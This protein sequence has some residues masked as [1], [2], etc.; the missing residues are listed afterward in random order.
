MEEEVEGGLGRGPGQLGDTGQDAPVQVAHPVVEQ[1]PLAPVQRAQHLRLA[2][3][4]RLLGSV[5]IRFVWL[6]C[7][8]KAHT[9]VCVQMPPMTY[10]SHNHFS[11]LHAVPLSTLIRH[12]A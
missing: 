9:I 5:F 1:P 10:L 2:T 7:V 6:S 12:R 3:S 8:F 4:M 11:V